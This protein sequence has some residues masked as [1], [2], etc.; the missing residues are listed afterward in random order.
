MLISK[1]EKSFILAGIMKSRLFFF[2]QKWRKEIKYIEFTI[3]IQTKKNFLKNF[4][5][6]PFN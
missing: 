3:I 2:D 1:G 6:K 4:H 5:N